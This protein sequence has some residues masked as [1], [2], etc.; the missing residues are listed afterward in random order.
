[1][2]CGAYW[3]CNPICYL[4]QCEV[5]G[6][7]REGDSVQGVELQ[8]GQRLAARSVVITTGTFLNGLIRIGDRSY[9]AGRN[10]ESPSILLGQYLKEPRISHR[11]IEDRNAAASGRPEDRLC[12]F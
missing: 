12:A 6:L 1:M 2:R 11:P 3:K 5:V 10:G 4:C 8:D 7:L 9:A